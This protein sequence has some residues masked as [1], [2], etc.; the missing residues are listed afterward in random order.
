MVSSVSNAIEVLR[1]CGVREGDMEVTWMDTCSLADVL[2]IWQIP[3]TT[4]GGTLGSKWSCLCLVSR[5]II[6]VDHLN[7]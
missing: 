3:L 4:L 1:W 7:S 5:L 6:V 2:S